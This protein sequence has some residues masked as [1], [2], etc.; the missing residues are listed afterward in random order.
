M[1][2]GQAGGSHAG[3]TR[4]SADSLDGGELGK[5]P[6][7]AHPSKK[8]RKGETGAIDWD[9]DTPSSPHGPSK[10]QARHVALARWYSCRGRMALCLPLRPVL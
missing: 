8:Q 4:R 5:A 3:G 7:D 1:P 6:E 2:V 9:A 10:P